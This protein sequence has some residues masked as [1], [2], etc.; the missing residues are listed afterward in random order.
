MGGRI[1]GAR[2]VKDI[3]RTL[4]TESTKQDSQRLKR[5]LRMAYGSKLGPLHVRYSCVAW[6]SCGLLTMGVGLSLTLL[7][8]LG[9]FSSH[10][11]ASSSLDLRVCTWS[12]IL[13]HAWLILLGGCSFL[14]G[15]GKGSGRG[16]KRGETGM[17]GRRG[18]NA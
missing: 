3:T 4:P 13:G 9:T 2:E 18:Y 6:C 16:G 17:S 15:N 1:I 14:K 11:V 5:Q 7:F 12:Y 10:W 8:A